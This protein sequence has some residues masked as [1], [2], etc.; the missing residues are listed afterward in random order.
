[1]KKEYWVVKEI[2]TPR[3]GNLTWGRFRSLEEAK[4]ALEK[5]QKKEPKE[6][7]KIYTTRYAEVDI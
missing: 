6:T 1:M 4:K 7:F 2:T 3:I 5:A